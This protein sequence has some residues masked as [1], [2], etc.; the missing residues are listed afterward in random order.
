MRFNGIAQRVILSVVPVITISTLLF[1]FVVHVVIDSQISGQINERMQEGLDAARYEIQQELIKNAGIA[2]SLAIYAESAGLASIEGQ[3]MREYLLRAIRL[4]GNTMGC[5]ILYEPYRLYPDKCHWG[6]Y[7]YQDEGGVVYTENY[8]DRVNYFSTPWYLDCRT[9]KGDVVWSDIYYDPVPDKIIISAAAPFFDS[10]GNLLGVAISDMSLATIQ[11]IVRSITVGKTGGAFVLGAGGEYISFLNDSRTMNDTIQHDRNP[12]LAALG[13]K[14]FDRKEGTTI[15]RKNGAAWRTHFGAIPETGW[16]L[17]ILINEKEIAWS[18]LGLV[19]ITGIVPFVGLILANFVIFSSA[20]YLR[21]IARKVNNFADLVASGNFSERIEITEKDE[22]GIMEGHLNRM[23]EKM[24]GMHQ[25]MRQMVENAQVASRAKSEFLSNMSHEIRT[26]MNAIIG[27]T[28]IAKHAADI[29]KKDYCLGKIGDAS[30]HLLGVINDI[31]DMS[32]IEANRLELSLE[33]FDFEKMI[34]KTINIIG[35]RVDEKSQRFTVR[36]GQDI[37]RFLI[38][39]DLRLSQ[40]ITNLLSNAVKFTP[41]YGN[42]RLEAR[43]TK[44][45]GRRCTIRF[46]VTDTGIGISEDQQSRL[47]SSF[48]QADSGISRKF[49]GTGLGLAISKRIVEMMNG[50]IWIQS[51]PGKGATF[52]FTIEA[53]TAEKEGLMGPGPG[54]KTLRLPGME[55]DPAAADEPEPPQ[56][57]F[58]GRR[59]LLAEDID[60]NR[61][62]VLSMLEPTGLAFD[63]AK[64]GVEAVQLYQ[65]SPDRYDLIFMDVQMP[66]MDGYEAAC[67]IRTIERLKNPGRRVPIIA[68]TA[69]VFREDVEKCLEAGMDDHVGKPLD[70]E[71][72]MKKLREYLGGDPVVAAYGQESY[73]KDT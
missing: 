3:E 18:T 36:I 58:E 4:N 38:G 73:T 12:D 5:G 42:I 57:N 7:V 29:G 10:A 47:F 8:G 19:L 28:A 22:F 55:E 69:N 9:A 66:E 30:A 25:N 44:K 17:V 16:T 31:L 14:I 46:E 41:E 51:E 53:D 33:E 26:P 62:I 35:F 52:C 49:G 39:D 63:C 34:L 64:N 56:E 40:I 59:A 27:M 2:K 67:R 50:R 43:L 32:K 37:P 71:E 6:P 70:Q 60:I 1:I 68:M 24:G 61:E 20:G 65:E 45:E 11:R 13:K 72:V 23:A 48:A 54:W 21:R 15:L